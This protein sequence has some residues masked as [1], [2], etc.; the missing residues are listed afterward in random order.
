MHPDCI[1]RVKKLAGDW[2]LEPEDLEVI[3]STAKKAMSGLE[4]NESFKNLKIADKVKALSEKEHLLLLEN[5]AFES[6]R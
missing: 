3:E 2:K 1:E 4:L 6:F 5:G